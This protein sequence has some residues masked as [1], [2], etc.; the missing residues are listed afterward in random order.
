MLKMKP[1]WSNQCD[2]SSVGHIMPWQSKH[3]APSHIVDVSD[4][5]AGNGNA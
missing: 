2:P 1:E 5:D 3:I 4:G